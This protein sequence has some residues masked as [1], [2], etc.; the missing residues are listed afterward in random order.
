MTRW[1]PSG[2]ITLGDCSAKAPSVTEIIGK[3]E[4]GSLCLVR[5]IFKPIGKYDMVIH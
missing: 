1:D 4:S 3:S 2:N 5:S